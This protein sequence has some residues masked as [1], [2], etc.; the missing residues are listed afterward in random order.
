MWYCRI[1]GPAIIQEGTDDLLYAFFLFLSRGGRNV[2]RESFLNFA[3]ECYG[4][5]FPWCVDRYFGWRMI[6][7]DELFV[8]VARH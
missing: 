7:F 2:V 1:C 4:V 8:D 6:V 3:G 5:W